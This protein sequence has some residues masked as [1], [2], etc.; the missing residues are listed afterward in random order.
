ML[1]RFVLKISR[2]YL[3][4]HLCPVGTACLF[5]CPFLSDIHASYMLYSY[6]HQSTLL[7][8]AALTYYVLGSQSSD[9][10]VISRESL[11][12]DEYVS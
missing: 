5:Y 11:A 4:A 3:L 12:Q 1:F 8:F 7:R 10:R 2:G 6:H 9:A